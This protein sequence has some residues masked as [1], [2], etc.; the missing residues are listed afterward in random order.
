[1]FTQHL[2]F[3][4]SRYLFINQNCIAYQAPHELNP[5]DLAQ[6]GLRPI[7][8]ATL[9]VEEFAIYW[10]R[11]YFADEP[12]PLSSF[13][14]SAWLE[15]HNLGGMPECL[16]VQPEML[17][18]VRSALKQLDPG[19]VIRTLESGY[20]RG[21]NSTINQ[22]Q[23]LPTHCIDPDVEMDNPSSPLSTQGWTLFRL[24]ERLEHYHRQWQYTP[25]PALPHRPDEFDEHQ[26]REMQFPRCPHDLVEVRLSDWLQQPVR[27]GYPPEP[28]DALRIEADFGWCAV[29]S[30]VRKAHTKPA[31]SPYDQHL[32]MVH[33]LKWFKSTVRSL[34]FPS[35]KLFGS[36]IASADLEDF[37]QFRKQVSGAVVAQLYR[38]L[39]N[40][41]PGLVLFPHTAQEF[42]DAVNMLGYGGGERCC[43]EL[44]GSTNDFPLRI[45]A[46]A[47][48]NRLNLLVIPSWSVTDLQTLS[49]PPP[50][51][52]MEVIDV[53]APGFAA[54]VYWLEQLLPG[55]QWEHSPTLLE[56]V[57]SML[58]TIPQ[59][60]Q[61]NRPALSGSEYARARSARAKRVDDDLLP[62]LL[63]HGVVASGLGHASRK[64]GGSRGH[65]S[66]AGAPQVI[67]EKKQVLSF[68]TFRER[69][70]W[71]YATFQCGSSLDEIAATLGISVYQ[72]QVLIREGRRV[73]PEP[74]AWY[75]GLDARSANALRFAGYTSREQ[76]YQAVIN[77]EITCKTSVWHHA[78]YEADTPKAVPGIGRVSF[79]K[80]L[81]WLG[82]DE[83]V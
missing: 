34:P 37:L 59:W 11:L 16:L 47:D 43:A 77:K 46:L 44:V 64:R 6:F 19:K 63:S 28:A 1:M 35:E 75:D 78:A 12:V 79:Q 57:K 83:E 8:V 54:I 32:Y 2:T 20:G 21:F 14:Y 33:E 60:E 70:R 82:I 45:F 4:Q 50:H 53:G 41:R 40:E 22:A 73:I 26:H 18:P 67:K 38:V 65:D 58:L 3:V 7:I 74:P 48:D 72:T 24:N 36:I 27:G 13:L 9:A 10:Q 30:G 68:A 61:A 29:V 5:A 56:M 55:Y 52:A 51:K 25:P 42:K 31:F 17:D 49:Q 80:I 23:Q 15:C 66:I 81:R 76:V 62:Q 69:A 71:I 39:F